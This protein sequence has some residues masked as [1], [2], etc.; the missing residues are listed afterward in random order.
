MYR[1]CPRHFLSK[2]LQ[3]IYSYFS[4]SDRLVWHYIKLTSWSRVLLEKVIIVRPLQKIPALCGTIVLIGVFTRAWQSPQSWARWI[5]PRPPILRSILILL[6]HLLM[7]LWRDLT[8]LDFLTKTWLVLLITPIHGKFP[9]CITLQNVSI[10]MFSE[11]QI[12]VLLIMLFSLSYNHFLRQ[13]SK[14]SPE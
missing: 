13:M 2:C 1:Y 9:V 4:R 7:H 11:V 10:I 3:Y 14:Y 12:M 5:P 8:L 6:C